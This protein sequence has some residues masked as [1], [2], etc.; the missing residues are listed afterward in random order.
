MNQQKLE[1]VLLIQSALHDDL[2]VEIKYFKDHDYY[3]AQGHILF[4]D[5]INKIIKMDDIDV[6]VNDVV[7]VTIM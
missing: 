1:N 7:K 3:T 6:R 5:H 2:E 4:I